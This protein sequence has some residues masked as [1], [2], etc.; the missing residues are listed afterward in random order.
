MTPRLLAIPLFIGFLILSCQDILALGSL[1]DAENDAFLKSV[2][3]IIGCESCHLP[4]KA[5]KIAR[6][7]LPGLCSDCHPNQYKEFARS[8]HWQ[9]KGAVC[10]DCHGSHDIRLVR[11]P[12]SKAYRSLVCGSCHM[13]PKEHFDQGPHK[14]GMEKTGALACASCHGNHDVQHPTMAAIE[15]ACVRCH[16]QGTPEFQMGQQ[17]KNLFE[18]IRDSLSLAALQIETADDLGLNTRK[19]MEFANDATGRFTKARLIWHGLDLKK[20][21]EEVRSTSKTTEKV[22]GTVSSLL[23]SHRLRRIGLA[24]AW[25]VI[26]ANVALLLLKKSRIERE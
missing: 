1:D 24:T 25:I 12:E 15:P 13:G 18:G 4:G 16:T 8:V 26:L 22:L 11:K 5:D 3:E 10:I 2:H 19:A 9:G 17:V 23:D 14:S 7:D 20:I 21:E 6:S